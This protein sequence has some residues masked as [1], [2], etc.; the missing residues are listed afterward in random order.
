MFPPQHAVPYQPQLVALL[1]FAG[2]QIAIAQTS[3]ALHVAPAQHSWVFAPQPALELL[4][5]TAWHVPDWHAYPELHVLPEQHGNPAFP[6]AVLLFVGVVV[7][8]DEKRS[9]RHC[10]LTQIVPV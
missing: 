4:A 10:P 7:L 5:A 6:H 9:G 1:L 2:W 8:L 3:P